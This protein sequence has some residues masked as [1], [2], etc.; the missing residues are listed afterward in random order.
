MGL[1]FNVNLSFKIPLMG[2]ICLSNESSSQDIIS[3][4]SQIKKFRTLT[5][6]IE[7]ESEMQIAYH[8]RNSFKLNSLAEINS[9]KKIG[10]IE[11]ES[12]NKKIDSK[13]IL[14][15]A[16]KI[17]EKKTG[18]RWIFSLSSKKGKKSISEYDKEKDIEVIKEIK[19]NEIIKK[20]LEIIPS[21]EIVSVKKLNQDN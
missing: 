21:S 19:K 18:Q 20:I 12:I 13:N 6:L 14:W 11:L 3:F 7:S 5:N 17:I 1:G 8:L 10:E 4:D 2:S 16:T 9:E 15:N